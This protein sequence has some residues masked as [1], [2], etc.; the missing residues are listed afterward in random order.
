MNL[1][2]DDIDKRCQDFL[3]TVYTPCSS[4][5]NKNAITQTDGEILY[6]SVTKL[7]SVMC[8]TEQD[9]FV[10]LGSG[11]GKIVAQVFLRSR[12]AEALGIEIGPELNEQAQAVSAKIQM[13]LPE[14]YLGRKLTFLLGDFFQLPLGQPTVVLINSTCFSLPMLHRLGEQ[15]NELPSVRMVLSL[16]PLHTL[17]YLEF[18]KAMRVECT[19][20]SALCYVYKL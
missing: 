3:N 9:V 8:L 14:L 15:I 10:D 13:V 1:S 16:R 7:M 17:K 20:D 5:P 12:V 4:L 11:A 18:K 2:I 19:W 6:A